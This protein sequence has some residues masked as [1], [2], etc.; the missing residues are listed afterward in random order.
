[1][2]LN[3]NALTTDVMRALGFLTR[4]P[5]PAK[6]FDGDDGKLTRTCRAFPIA[7]ALATTPS[8]VAL[9]IASLLQLP[10]LL[11]AVIALSTLIATCG[12]LHDDGLADVADGF[13]GGK[14]TEQR[15]DIMKDS[16]IGTYGAL[17]SLMAFS[18][19][20]VAIAAVVQASLFGAIVALIGAAAISRGALIWHWSELESARQGGTS[21]K[22][23]S[24]SEDAATFAVSTA[25][26]IGL[27]CGFFAR[28][29]LPTIIALALTFLV[30]S[31]FK[32]LCAD[33]IGG[34]TGDTLGASAILAEIAFLIGLASGI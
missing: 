33:K 26:A 11:S 10:P 34:Q 6:W 31:S 19:R 22:V 5:I 30:T 12:A 9:L 18:M 17:A 32:R 20:V 24:P 29:I 23:G 7:G 28:G 15:L 13:F 3:P 4:L 27:M 1:M 2:D 14:S 8:I 16:R 25:L 21:D